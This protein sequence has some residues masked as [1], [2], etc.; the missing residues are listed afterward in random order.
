[1]FTA[2]QMSVPVITIDGP[3]G[4]GK[5]TI[6]MRLAQNLGW[7]FLDSGALYRVVAVAAMERA[8]EAD[9]EQALGEL[10][11]NL[12]VSFSFTGDEVVILLDGNRITGKLRSEETGVFASKIAAVP[13]VR[14]ALVKRQRAFRKL[15]GLVADGRDMGT[16]IFPDAKLKIFLTASVQA[17]ADRRYKQLKEKG[18]SVNLSRLFRDIKK[19]DKRDMSRSISPLTPAED[20]LLIDSTDMSIEM[21][22][23]EI[24]ILLEKIK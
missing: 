7:N 23:K 1:M 20:A 16:V 18:E 5:G 14:A 8:I 2:E 17:R 19:R 10:A 15:P 13:A 3:G 12:D 24:H 6:A 11:G 9:N 4:S 21:V 22:L